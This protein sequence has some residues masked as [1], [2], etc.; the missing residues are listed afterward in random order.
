MKDKTINFI[1]YSEFED[2][3]NE[4]PHYIILS[5]IQM[6]EYLVVTFR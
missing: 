2:F 5:T 6:R 4:N 3:V 1:S